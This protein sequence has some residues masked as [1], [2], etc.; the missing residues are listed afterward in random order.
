M[1]SII[2]I[3]NT[4]LYQCLVILHGIQTNINYKRGEIKIMRELKI[5]GVYKH[6]KGNLYIVQDILFIIVNL[7]R[8][9]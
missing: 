2:G 1:I 3:Q 6:Y 7:V 4:Q 8:K 5:N 9:W